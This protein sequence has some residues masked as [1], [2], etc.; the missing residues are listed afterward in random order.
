MPA[1][2]DILERYGLEKGALIPI[3][4]EV[5]ENIGYLSQEAISQIS[6]SV[7]MSESEIYGVASFYSQ[8][9][10]TPRGKHTV[11]VCLGTACHVRGG[12]RIMDEVQKQ[13]GIKSGE[14]TN[15]Y[16]YS[17]D[18]V[19]CFG[20]CA[21][22]PVMVVDKTVF[23]RMSSARVNDILNEYRQ[24]KPGELQGNI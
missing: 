6:K 8:F 16:N 23:G 10:F 24:D 7:N 2:N 9:Y 21:L 15:D 13:L 19:A 1:I 11:K 5:Q 12:Q 4:Q 22:G 20:S 18:A 17:L 3:L 14:T